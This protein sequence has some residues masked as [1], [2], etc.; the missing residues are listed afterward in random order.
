ML[1]CLAG[2]PSAAIAETAAQKPVYIGKRSANPE[3]ETFGFQARQP[4]GAILAFRGPARYF[5]VRTG[6]EEKDTFAYEPIVIEVEKTAAI[7][8]VH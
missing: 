4:G 6:D 5:G 8:S 3:Q 2:L 7:V 1:Y